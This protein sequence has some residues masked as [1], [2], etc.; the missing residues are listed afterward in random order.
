MHDYGYA[1]EHAPLYIIAQIHRHGNSYITRL[2]PP[3]S[4]LF[5]S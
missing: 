5:R 2:E 4:S 3:I 1:G